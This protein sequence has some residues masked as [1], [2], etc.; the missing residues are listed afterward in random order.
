MPKSGSV[1]NSR[2]SMPSVMYF[3]IVCSEVQSSKRIL[4]PTSDPSLT[5]ISCE[6]RA[7]TDMAATRRGCVHPIR[8]PPL[9]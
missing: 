6:T 2:K 5:D 3:I 4:Y 1:R 9:Q 8:F 7:A